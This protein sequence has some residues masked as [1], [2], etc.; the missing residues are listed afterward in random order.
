LSFALF[1]EITQRL[2]AVL[3]WDFRTTCPSH[4]KRWKIQETRIL[5]K[6]GRVKMFIFKHNISKFYTL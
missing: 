1:R 5:G 6:S 4:L 2:V 3:Y